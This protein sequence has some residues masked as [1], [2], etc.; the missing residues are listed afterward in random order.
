MRRSPP[1]WSG[2]WL[3]VTTDLRRSWRFL[4][5]RPGLEPGTPRSKRG[6]IFRFTTGARDRA[7]AAQLTSLESLF[8]WVLTAAP[9]E[10]I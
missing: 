8:L 1:E 3:P 10:I 5:P 7:I 2:A 6:M 9:P 4:M